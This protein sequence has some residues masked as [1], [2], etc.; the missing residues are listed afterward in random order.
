MCT[1]TVLTPRVA[2]L[3]SV[4]PMHAYPRTCSACSCIHF[5]W[6]AHINDCRA[7]FICMQA[8]AYPVCVYTWVCRS[9][10]PCVACAPILIYERLRCACMHSCTLMPSRMHSTCAHLPM[11]VLTSP[12]VRVG[13]AGASKLNHVCALFHAF[14][15]A[16]S[17]RAVCAY[18]VPLNLFSVVCVW[19]TLRMHVMV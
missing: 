8:Q 5:N 13:I 17:V 10:R 6:L 1:R 9:Q 2:L 7:A 19:G 4:L 15:I 14:A 16:H 11:I 12:C 18:I 3:P